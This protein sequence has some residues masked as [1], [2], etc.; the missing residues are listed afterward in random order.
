M[1]FPNLSLARSTDLP[2]I[3]TVLLFLFTYNLGDFAGKIIGD[4]R[5][6]FNAL[7][8]VFLFFSRLFFFYTIPMMVVSY[9]QEDHVLNNNFFPFINQFLFALTNGFVTSKYI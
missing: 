5:G 2:G 9:T 7:S 1:L 8:M 3:W 4:F 6:S